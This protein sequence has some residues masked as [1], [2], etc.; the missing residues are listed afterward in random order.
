M[1]LYDKL[2]KAGI[3]PTDFGSRSGIIL[4]DDSDGHG[5]YIEVWQCDKPLP[6]GFKIGK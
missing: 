4:R 3:E 5:E 2:I 1:V 6:E